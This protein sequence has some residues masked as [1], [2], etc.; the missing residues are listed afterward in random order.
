MLA[1][2]RTLLAQ[3]AALDRK[4]STLGSD[5]IRILDRE[6]VYKHLAEHH[7]GAE[8][9]GLFNALDSSV[10][11]IERADWVTRCREE[12]L[13]SLGARRP[14]LEEGRARV[15]AHLAGTPLA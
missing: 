8:E 11:T 12:F 15:L 2:L 1:H 3:V 13:A 10:D 14:L 9:L 6:A 7:D 5:L 4:S